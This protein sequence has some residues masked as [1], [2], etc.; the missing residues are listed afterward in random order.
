MSLVAND[1]A[2][3]QTHPLV[4]LPIKKEKED[5]RQELRDLPNKGNPWDYT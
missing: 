3:K 1:P 5:T 4:K 2:S